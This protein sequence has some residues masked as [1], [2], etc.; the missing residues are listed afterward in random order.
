M[1]GYGPFR[2]R[3]IEGKGIA[4]ENKPRERKVKVGEGKFVGVGYVFISV[5]CK[6]KEVRVVVSVYRQENGRKYCVG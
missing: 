3:D 5:N 4:D 2:E 6:N 1:K